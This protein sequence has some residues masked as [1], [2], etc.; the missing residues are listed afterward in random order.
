MTTNHNNFHFSDDGRNTT[1][2]SEI[3]KKDLSELKKWINGLPDNY[4]YETFHIK[5]KSG[6]LRKIEAPNELLKDLQLAIYHKLLRTQP[7]QTVAKGFV[8]KRSI[9]DNAIPHVNSKLIIKIDLKDFFHNI[10]VSRVYK[11]WLGENWDSESSKILTNICCN[12]NYLPQGAPTSPVLS[13]LVNRVFDGIIEKVAKKYSARYT[14]YADDLTF[15][16]PQNIN[17]LERKVKPLIKEVKNKLK[18][19]KYQIQY[20]KGIRFLR[21]HQRQVVTGIVVNK[22][23]N[24]P[25]EKRK[26]IRSM[27]HKRDL[28]IL[29]DKDVRKLEGYESLLSMIDNSKP[30][31]VK[32]HKPIDKQSTY[33]IY[34]QDGGI[35]AMNEKGDIVFGNQNK[36]GDNI[37]GI[38]NVGEFENVIQTLNK[39]DNKE[40][41][42]ALVQ[43]TESIVNS[44]HLDEEQ[45]KSHNEALTEIGKEVAKDQP[46]KT[47]IKYMWEGLQSTLKAV[48]D[49]VKAIA[50]I[51]PFIIKFIA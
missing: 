30:S 20:E 8:I 35:M 22:D 36:A 13:N 34:I 41:A 5:K 10:S 17:K 9:I 19:E 7:I 42:N 2:L 4:S 16:F 33:K 31:K 24:L 44:K 29:L 32:E 1:Q 15:S 23:I 14:R 18:A 27:R 45:K 39:S 12:N 3:L 38:Q 43:L 28:G 25:R 46:N 48:P 26:L 37:G 40:F 47:T 11:F 51:S 49:V 6:K 21:P 50:A